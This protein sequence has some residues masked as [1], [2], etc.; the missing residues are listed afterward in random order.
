MGGTVWLA[1]GALA[2]L[3][4][5]CGWCGNSCRP[6]KDGWAV[7]AQGAQQSLAQESRF[8]RRVPEAVYHAIVQERRRVINGDDL[9]TDAEEVEK[10]SKAQQHAHREAELLHDTLLQV[11]LPE[12]EVP[13]MESPECLPGSSPAEPP[14]VALPDP[15]H[16]L[17]PGPRVE[18]PQSELEPPSDKPRRRVA[19]QPSKAPRRKKRKDE[20]AP[21]ARSD[22]PTRHAGDG[23]AAAPATLAGQGG[24]VSTR[25]ESLRAE[26]T[27]AFDG[28]YLT[29]AVTTASGHREP[30][31]GSDEESELARFGRVVNTL[32]V[33]VEH[34]ARLAEVRSS[35]SSALE[36]ADLP[37]LHDAGCGPPVLWYLREGS[38]SGS[39]VNTSTQVSAL[40][41]ARRVWLAPQSIPPSRPSPRAIETARPPPPEAQS[42]ADLT[43]VL[44]SGESVRI[45]RGHVQ[46]NSALD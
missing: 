17:P 1:A 25:R 6:K 30:G 24:D 32:L 40:L 22:A 11:V 43:K 21:G 33:D 31:E 3:V 8:L 39:I 37:E 29:V 9:A 10:G 35:I 27:V 13:T 18:Q 34:A 45:Y 2:L 28:R 23:T 26:A 4:Y 7:V 5:N 36:D 15:P 46:G 41:K 38:S 14:P 12:P 19:R 20:P 42:R 16:P 44:K